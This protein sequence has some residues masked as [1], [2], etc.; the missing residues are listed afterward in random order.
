MSHSTYLLLLLLILF[1]EVVLLLIHHQAHTE[2]TKHVQNFLDMENDK[3]NKKIEALQLT[4]HESHREL[5]NKRAEAG[6]L[7]NS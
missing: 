3:L 7:R 4:I 2:R 6:S 5:E 1:T